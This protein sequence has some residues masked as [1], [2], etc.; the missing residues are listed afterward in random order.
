MDVIELTS[1]LIE[2][3]SISPDDGGSLNFIIKIL[4]QNKFKCNKLIFGEQEKKTTNLYASLTKGNGPNICFAGHTDVVPPG[5]LDNW[6]SDPF[7]AKINNGYIFGRG[8]CDMKGAV[9]AFLVSLIR[10]SKNHNF[11]GTV[12]LILT[13]DEEGTADYGTK[14]VIEWIKE[15]KIK[16]D[17][18]LVG[19]PTNPGHLGQ[20]VKIGRRGSLNGKLIVKGKQGH[21]AYPEKCINPNKIL[22]SF[23]NELYKPFDKGSENFQP[24]NLEITSIDV[25]NQVTNLIPRDATVKFNVRFNNSFSSDSIVNKIKNRLDKINKNYE[26]EVKVSGESFLNFSKKMNKLMTQSIYEI[27]GKTPDLSTSGGTSDA[28]FIAQICPV[29]EF[30][31]VGQTMHQVDENVLTD[32]IISLTEIYFLFLRKILC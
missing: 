31:L 18:C 29:I 19:E 24:S 32:D 3:K 13:S 11:N 10:F 6:T 21:V 22:L 9:A 1:K 15:K 8:A 7:K 16:I 5:D 28:R 25:N 27:T 30:G 12:S 20:M 4:E 17:Y 23:C 2:F 26:L 14:K